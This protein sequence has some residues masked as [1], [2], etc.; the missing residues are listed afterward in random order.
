MLLLAAA[1]T[2]ATGNDP[3][4]VGCQLQFS[5][6]LGGP[7]YDRAYAVE[8]DQDGCVYIAGRA[9]P[10]FP[11]TAGAIQPNFGGD[12]VSGPSAA[13]GKQDGFITKLASDGSRLIWSTYFGDDVAGFIRD[14]DIDLA[15]DVYVVSPA[16]PLATCFSGWCSLRTLYPV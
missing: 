14:L 12:I 11:A 8:V 5:T 1:E 7:N 16:N 6:Y 2:L 15:G 9:G 3:A 13:Y 10:G 4:T